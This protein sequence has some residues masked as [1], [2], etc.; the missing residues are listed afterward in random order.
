MR[1]ALAF[2]AIAVTLSASVSARD[3]AAAPGSYT[4]TTSAAEDNRLAKN[5]A[6]LNKVT[7]A[8][9]GLTVGCTQ[10][11]ARAVTPGVDVYSDSLDYLQRGPLSDLLKNLKN[12]DNADDLTVFC[13][14]WLNTSNQT[15]RNTHCTDAGLPAGCELCK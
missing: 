7:C 9:A 13:G 5:V 8:N 11:Q 15:Q 12:A 10:S 1:K 4:L 14:W 2:V 6:R 3:A